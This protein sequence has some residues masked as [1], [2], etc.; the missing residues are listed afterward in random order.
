MENAG[1][2]CEAAAVVVVTAALAVVFFESLLD[3]DISDSVSLRSS[4]YIAE[5]SASIA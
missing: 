1:G 3:P 5:C 2:I 4:C